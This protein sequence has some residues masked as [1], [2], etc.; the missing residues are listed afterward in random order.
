MK[1]YCE[2]HSF[3]RLCIVAAFAR[4]RLRGKA[5]LQAHIGGVGL[6]LKGIEHLQMHSSFQ[7]RAR[8]DA[9]GTLRAAPSSLSVSASLRLPLWAFAASRYDF[10]E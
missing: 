6:V 9:C 4:R 8:V 10:H 1:L 5:L 7:N 2:L 3:L